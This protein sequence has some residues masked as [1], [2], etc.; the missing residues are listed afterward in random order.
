[1][2]LDDM[3]SRSYLG[4]YLDVLK[5]LRRIDECDEME[6]LDKSK[7]SERQVVSAFSKDL[8]EQNCNGTKP[9]F[10]QKE[11]T[12]DS[13]DTVKV[14]QELCEA[15]M[16]INSG[17]SIKEEEGKKLMED[18]LQEIDPIMKKIKDHGATAI[19][20]LIAED[21]Y[22]KQ[23]LDFFHVNISDES[24]HPL[25]LLGEGVEFMYDVVQGRFSGEKAALFAL[26]ATKLALKIGGSV[27]PFPG[28]VLAA[29]LVDLGI[30]KLSE[31]MIKKR[32][33]EQEEDME[34]QRELPVETLCPPLADACAS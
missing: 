3:Q 27:I 16:A 30:Q 17:D 9:K 5:G 32:K 10:Q 20:K 29:K 4:S 26:K 33:R 7:C 18:S 6:P 11:S 31:E 25:S 21:F 14:L 12:A 24:A 34:F 13:G 19:D 23:I 8:Q 1:M 28:N 22:F 2:Q 15:A